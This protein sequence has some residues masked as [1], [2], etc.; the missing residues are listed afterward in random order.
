MSGFLQQARR[1]IVSLFTLLSVFYANPRADAAD[2]VVLKYRFLRQTVSVSELTLK[3][4][5]TILPQKFMS[6]AIALLK[7]FTGLTKCLGVCQ[8]LDFDRV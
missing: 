1:F 7:L 2:T 8:I 5:K 4:C 3:R 6:R